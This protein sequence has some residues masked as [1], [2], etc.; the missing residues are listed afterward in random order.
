MAN[1][2]VGGQKPRRNEPCP[3]GSGLKFKKCHGDPVK[4]TR[5]MEVVREA[6]S[7]EMTRLVTED[8]IAKAGTSEQDINKKP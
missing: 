4:H 3:C 6:Y 5:A 1:T 7:R 2:I 8:A